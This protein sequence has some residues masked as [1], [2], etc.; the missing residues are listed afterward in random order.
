MLLSELAD[1][2]SPAVHCEVVRDGSFDNLGY[3]THRTNAKPLLVFVAA[4]K[5]LTALIGNPYVSAVLTTS[6]LAEHIPEH[7]GLAVVRDPLIAFYKAHNF[8]LDSNFYWQPFENQID[9]TSYISPAAIIADRNVRIGAGTVIEAGVHIKERTIIGANCIVR[10]GTI[11]SSEGFEYKN[12]GKGLELIPH[13]AGIEIGDRVNIHSNCAMDRGLYG[14][15]TK[16]GSGSCIDNFVHIA[17][18]VKIGQNCIVAAGTVFAAAVIVGDGARIDPN[19]TVGHEVSIGPRAYVS[20]G[21]VVVKDVPADTKVSGNFALDHRR[22]V[23]AWL[24]N[25]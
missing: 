13:G 21:S 9:S 8:L 19:A 3:V 22:F 14:E 1:A 11:L 15:N 6:E 17:H 10:S 20:M 5:F 24:K 12:L 23:K 18:G 2:L 4:R 25:S 7:I 16:I